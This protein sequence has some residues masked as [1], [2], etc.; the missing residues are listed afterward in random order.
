MMNFGLDEPTVIHGM[1]MAFDF[2]TKRIGVAIGQTIT[3]TASPIKPLLATDGVPDWVELE[4]LINHWHP[5]ALVVGVPVHNGGLEEL[6]T[7]RAL[8]FARKLK[9]RFKLPVFGVDESFTSEAARQELYDRGGTRLIKK[10]SIDSIAAQLICES[11]LR[12]Y[13]S[14]L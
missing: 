2:G 12:M 11:W 8:K 14:K 1:I 4:T 9:T 10:Q 5:K 7:K 3:Q 6:I 13:S